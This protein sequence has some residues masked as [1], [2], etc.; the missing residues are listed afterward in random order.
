MIDSVI[1]AAHS[2]LYELCVRLLQFYEDHGRRL[3]GSGY[4][5]SF[6][7]WVDQRN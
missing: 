1:F 6:R 7:I 5:V 3:S 2:L 4:T